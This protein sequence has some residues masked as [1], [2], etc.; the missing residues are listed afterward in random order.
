MTTNN[1]PIA[2]WA[3]M[4]KHD[5]PHLLYIMNNWGAEIATLTQQLCQRLES[6]DFNYLYEALGVGMDHL[7]AAALQLSVHVA[8]HLDSL[9]D[10]QES[11]HGVFSYDY[12]ED[13]LPALLM[14][15]LTEEEWYELA[16]NYFVPGTLRSLLLK[17]VEGHPDLAL[18]AEE[19][20]Q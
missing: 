4:T 17:W 1:P 6:P 14:G 18:K 10:F 15:T 11:T 8:H 13:T 16:A 7:R 3:P 20:T 9:I 19:P 2:A 5:E 12:C